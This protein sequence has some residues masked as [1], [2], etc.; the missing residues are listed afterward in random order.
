MKD[1]YG[2]IGGYLDENWHG[3]D[4][5]GDLF[6]HPE[7]DI[8]D[9]PAPA[10]KE[11][12]VAWNWRHAM[13][14]E[15]MRGRRRDQIVAK[16]G[17]AMKKFGVQDEV[18]EFLDDNDGVMGWL[19]VDVSN[20]DA[21]FG[22]EDIPEFM[23]KCNLYA[24]NATELREI[25]SRSLVSENDGTL[26]G[27]LGSDDSV[28]EKSTY[29]DEI[30]GLPC[31]DG[32]TE[33]EMNQ[34]E[35]LDK[36]AK[37]FYGKRWLAD[38]DMAAFNVSDNKIGILTSAIL[39]HGADVSESTGEF[40][41]DT[42][43]F[44][45]RETKVNV[46]PISQKKDVDV[47]GVHEAKVDDIGNTAMPAPVKVQQKYTPS[48]IIKKDIEYSKQAPA[49]LKVDPIKRQK[50]DGINLE[51]K[52]LVKVDPIKRQKLDDIGAVK[53]VKS[54]QVLDNPNREADIDEIEISD[55]TGYNGFTNGLNE[56]T[57][58]SYR[59]DID[60]GEVSGEF[61][62]DDISDMKDD[63]FDY[64]DVSDG[65]VDLDEMM[66]DEADRNEAEVDEVPEEVEISNKYDWSW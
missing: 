3:G 2:D 39:R 58:K 31:M 12:P 29:I 17:D 20:F 61:V 55:E 37:M 15:L 22:Y 25:I 40:T 27:F 23:R 57:K 62:I 24:V 7:M 16:Y 13:T 5:A 33:E 28:S 51:K 35:R 6:S 48:E 43:D 32:L 4:I 56:L 63:E 1:S 18:L 53:P 49:P 11:K 52:P 44:G 64:G 8:T 38:Q 10:K 47:T 34:D 41:D 14:R 50:L 26:D 36:I 9:E 54:Q 59:T 65:S 60:L 46:D 30:T 42:G 21:K 66:E 19:V 45:I